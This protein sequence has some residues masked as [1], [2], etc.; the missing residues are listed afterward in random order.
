MES[1]CVFGKIYLRLMLV[2]CPGVA[3]DECLLAFECARLADVIRRSQDLR[4]VSLRCEVSLCM[5]GHFFKY[6]IWSQPNGKYT[7]CCVVVVV[8]F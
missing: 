7:V 3:G 5:A 4:V 2:F 1:L 8:V 6:G